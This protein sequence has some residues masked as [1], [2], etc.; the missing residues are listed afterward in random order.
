MAASLVFAPRATSASPWRW[1]RVSCPARI[2]SAST[3]T[4]NSGT[5]GGP[6]P[7]TFVPYHLL[8]GRGPANSRH[9]TGGRDRRTDS[10][11]TRQAVN[12]MIEEHLG[13]APART[14]SRRRRRYMLGFDN[15]GWSWP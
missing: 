8:L 13:R 12:Q 11:T 6:E 15:L 14:S 2:A 1:S 9:R 7:P 5:T 10:Q 4:W 3:A